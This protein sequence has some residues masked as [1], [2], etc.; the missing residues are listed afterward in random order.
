MV[1]CEYL[2]YLRYIV[3]DR[4]LTFL[5]F[6]NDRT[7]L[8]IMVLRFKFKIFRLNSCSRGPKIVSDDLNLKLGRTARVSRINLLYFFFSPA[9]HG[10]PQWKINLII[11]RIGEKNFIVTMESMRGSNSPD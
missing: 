7:C 9:R 3:R 4:F 11:C 1:R 8:D 6:E 5:G 2:L 10:S